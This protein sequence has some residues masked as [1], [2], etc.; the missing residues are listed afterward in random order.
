MN[1][2]TS[3]YHLRGRVQ[4]RKSEV[5]STLACTA[6]A[7]SSRLRIRHTL[8]PYMQSCLSVR[9]APTP[10]SSPQTISPDSNPIAR[11]PRPPQTPAT[12]F[13][14]P[15]RNCPQA[16]NR[17]PTRLICRGSPDRALTFL[18]TD[19]YLVAK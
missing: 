13:K 18:V 6:H 17:V 2:C 3:N 16:E 14:R 19:P 1:P 9:S 15:Y 11:S 7:R 5:R 4:T 12:H 8:H 10:V